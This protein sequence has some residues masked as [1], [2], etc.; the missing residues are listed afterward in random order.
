MIQATTLGRPGRRPSSLAIFDLGIPLYL[1]ILILCSLVL[2]EALERSSE[3]VVQKAV[4]RT[5][6]AKETHFKVRSSLLCT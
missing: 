2:V 6:P 5:A 1:E 4:D 3:V